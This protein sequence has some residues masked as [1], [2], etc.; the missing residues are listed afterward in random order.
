MVGPVV[1]NLQGVEPW[2][3]LSLCV[4]AWTD[5][6][7]ALT[8]PP[9]TSGARARSA[10]WAALARDLASLDK[11]LRKLTS[12]GYRLHVVYEAGPCVSVIWRHLTALGQSCDVVAPRRQQHDLEHDTSVVGAGADLVVV[13]ARIHAAEVKL[14]IDEVVKRELEGARLDLLVQH[15]WDQHAASLERLV[16]RHRSPRRVELDAQPMQ[17][18]RRSTTHSRATEGFL[19]SLNV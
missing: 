7:R 13:E 17:M 15:Y 1:A 11:A 5:T 4:W 6:K 10:T 18:L 3:N 8:S 9:R 12:K 14:V 2:R 19:H 16:A